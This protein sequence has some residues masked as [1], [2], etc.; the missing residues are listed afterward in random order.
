MDGG[1][2]W[3]EGEEMRKGIG[4]RGRKRSSKSR[5]RYSYEPLLARGRDPS[6]QAS[7]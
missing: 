4:R 2:E 1:G 5:S 6:L 7:A 3:V